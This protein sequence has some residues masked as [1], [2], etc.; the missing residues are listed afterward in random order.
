MV[1]ALPPIEQLNHQK[2]GNYY[3]IKGVLLANIISRD[4]FPGRYLLIIYNDQIECHVGGV[5]LLP[6]HLLMIRCIVLGDY[7]YVIAGW[8]IAP[9]VDNEF[10]AAFLYIKRLLLYNIA[11]VVHQS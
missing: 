7:G 11:C 3:V 6:D 1:L 8:Y 5:K 4:D 9:V 2:A 10:I